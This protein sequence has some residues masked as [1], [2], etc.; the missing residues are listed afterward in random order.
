MAAYIIVAVSFNVLIFLAGSVGNSLVLYVYSKKSIQTS[1]NV[2]IRTLALSDFMVCLLRL[3]GVYHWTHERNY[4]I[5]FLCPVFLTS[6][7]FSVF[8]SVLITVAIAVD[9][10]Y[11][12]CRAG[13]GSITVFRAKVI[14]VACLSG[15]ALMASPVLFVYG[16]VEI[17]PNV[18]YCGAINPVPILA[19]LSFLIRLFYVVSISII[20]VMYIRVYMTIRS[21]AK[22]LA[23]HRQRLFRVVEASTVAYDVATMSGDHTKT[24]GAE[25]ESDSDVPVSRNVGGTSE[26]IETAKSTP[27]NDMFK[28]QLVVSTN[29]TRS[30]TERNST[31]CRQAPQNGQPATASG[32]Q[33]PQTSIRV[34]LQRKTTLM[35]LMT[36]I[37]LFSTW[38]PSLIVWSL[39]RQTEAKIAAKGQFY[40]SILILGSYTFFVNNAVNP[41]IYAFVNRR[42]RE[43][44]AM[45]FKNLKRKILNLRNR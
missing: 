15:A 45:V 35:L 2:F 8:S 34:R 22:V 21:K 6:S 7:F 44:C 16:V 18:R 26:K 30:F 32:Q 41:V 29:V 27:N 9:R 33:K 36:S 4:Q 43:D 23:S 38:L 19:I 17:A 1:T 12:V 28:A 5:A 25:H 40:R 37:V 42:F 24:I 31:E 14:S 11:A 10:F 3:G 13:R 20:V 39:S